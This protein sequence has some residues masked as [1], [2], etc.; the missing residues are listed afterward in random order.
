MIGAIIAGAGALVSAGMAIK[1]NQNSRAASEAAA[2]YANQLKGMKET[3]LMAALQSPDIMKL[4]NQQTAQQAASATQAIQGGGPEAAAQI[5]ALNKGVLDANAEAALMQSKQNYQRDAA[6]LTNAQ[7]VENRNIIAQRALVN[8]QLAGSQKAAA[9]YADM[10]SKNIEGAISG[11]GTVAGALD[12]DILAYLNK[13]KNEVP[14]VGDKT[15]TSDVGS[16]L[17]QEDLLLA[18]QEN[19]DL[20]QEFLDFKNNNVR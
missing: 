1:N 12:P 6:V 5:S 3:N 19:P 8:S 15:L 2:V 18:F 16:N 14:P 9:N 10:A 7:E 17:K 11:L 20:F 13:K 4:L